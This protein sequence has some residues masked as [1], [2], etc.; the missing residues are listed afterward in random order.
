SLAIQA[1]NIFPIAYMILTLF[2]KKAKF[3]VDTI[4]VYIITTISATSMILLGIFWNKTIFVNGTEISIAFI[5]LVFALGS[6]DCCTS[7]V[8]FPIIGNYKYHYS[9]ALSLG[10][11]TTGLIVG[12]IGLIQQ[13]G[14]DE[15]P[16][17]SVLIMC[18]LI[19]II[20]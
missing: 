8:Y 11:S 12:I 6:C 1:G 15:G 14:R 19:V 3:I 4:S 20:I 5:I 17:F 9:S 7:V 16:L 10:M 18:V 13:P 2:V